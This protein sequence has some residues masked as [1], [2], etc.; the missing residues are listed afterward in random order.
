M[1]ALT[2]ALLLAAASPAAAADPLAGTSWRLVSI[3]G[4]PI[5]L[6]ARR[7]TVAFGPDGR[8]SG[9][10]GC[11]TFGGYRLEGGRLVLTGDGIVT[12]M[13]CLSRTDPDLMNRGEAFRDALEGA[14][15]RL[16]GDLLRL[17]SP[18][19][20]RVKLRRI[21]ATPQLQGATWRLHELNGEPVPASA[22]GAMLRLDD[23]E[24]AGSDGCNGV[25]GTYQ[26]RKDAVTFGELGQTTMSCGA[27]RDMYASRFQA[28][29]KGDLKVRIEPDRLRL[30]G[31]GGGSAVLTPE[32]EEGPP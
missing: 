3:T 20:V 29:L 27:E 5:P 17:R 1:S 18:D 7:A 15:V 21:V 28:L 30:E 22:R 23:G 2:I 14:E 8:L 24:V 31:P 11:N 10:D 13:A 9:D 4:H 19:G 16:D 26:L 25:W 12:T 6:R 32:P